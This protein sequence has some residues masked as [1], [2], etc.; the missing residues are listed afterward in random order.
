MTAVTVIR[1]IPPPIVGV[2]VPA[3]EHRVQELE[4]ALDW[5]EVHGV[6]VNRIDPVTEGADLQDVPEAARLWDAEGRSVLPMV[7]VDGHVESQGRFPSRHELAHL[8]ATHQAA[9]AV[10]AGR[11]TVRA[12]T[13]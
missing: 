9:S 1:H 4:S 7:V 10:D 13:C 5:L 8:V 12:G 2:C 3:P 6:I 11:H